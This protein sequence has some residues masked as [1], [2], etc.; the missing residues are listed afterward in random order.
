MFVIP[1]AIFAGHFSWLEY[2]DNFIP[3]LLGNAVGGTVFIGIAYWHA[4][5]N[6]E[7]NYKEAKAIQPVEKVG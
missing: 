1:A 4:Y 6:N 3:V 5:K 2:I 7:S